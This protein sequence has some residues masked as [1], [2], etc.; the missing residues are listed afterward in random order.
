MKEADALRAEIKALEEQ[1]SESIDNFIK[2][3]G[4]CNI[5]GEISVHFYE[6]LNGNR[7]HTGTQVKIKVII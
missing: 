7:K 4:K 3:H 5:E 1:I 6:N 2:E